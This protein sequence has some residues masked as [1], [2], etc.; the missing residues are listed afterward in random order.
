MV[1]WHPPCA[2]ISLIFSSLDPETNCCY[3]EVIC[4][5]GR[6]RSLPLQYLLLRIATGLSLNLHLCSC[7]DTTSS[8]L[9]SCRNCFRFLLNPESDTELIS[10]TSTAFRVTL[11]VCQP[12]SSEFDLPRDSVALLC[13]PVTAPYGVFVSFRFSPSDPFLSDRPVG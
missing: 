9:L 4:A 1:P 12:S 10:Q 3:F 11:C 5:F 7:Q 8:C 6:F 13:C 2:L